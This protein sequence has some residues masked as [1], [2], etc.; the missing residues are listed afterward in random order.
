[1]T[2]RE[3]YRRA[4]G[5]ASPEYVP[6][7][8]EVDLDWLREKDEAKV[9]RIRGLQ[10]LFP[11]DML[12]WLGAWK[13]ATEP[14]RGED[15]A[16]RWT[17]EWGV[18]WV[19]RGLGWFA[20]KHPLAGGYHLL[21]SYAF[22]DPHAPGRFDEDDRR[23]AERGERYVMARVWFTLFER[24]WLLRGFENV[25]V[26]PYLDE[27]SFLRLRDRIVEIDLEMID[28]WLER[29]VDGV[30]FSD[31][32]GSQKGLFISPKDWRRL[33]RPCYERLFTRVR[34]GGAHVWMHSCGN[35]TEIVQDLIDVGL[36]V[37]N[38]VQSSAMDVR[39][40]ARRFAGR[41][42]F[43]GGV[44]VQETLIR[45]T[46]GEVRREVHELV[47]LFGSRGGGYIGGTSHSVMPET[48]LDNVIA[49]YEA[50]AEHL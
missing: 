32:W 3:N 48:P 34:D 5:F 39:E 21:D 1:M 20:E 19:S 16:E 31:D 9:A 42:C 43:N 4:I 26:D 6:A 15:G 29:G 33:Y 47:E 40:L 12:R 35:V 38:P 36:N 41:L 44:N 28:L 7:R 18:E 27:K 46:P 2:G 14:V 13:K 45:G 24:L 8:L 37:L 11:D 23:L 22:P 50:F 49:L 30:F 17:D 25:L 10:S